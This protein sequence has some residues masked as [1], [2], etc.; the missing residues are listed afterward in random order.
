MKKQI[1]EY[2]LAAFEYQF[3][4]E[5][6]SGVFCYS[7][8]HFY[9]YWDVIDKEHSISSR[10][11]SFKLFLISKYL[12]MLMYYLTNKNKYFKKVHLG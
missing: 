8:R 3:G 4:G 12:H 10:Y 9:F 2:N 1:K 6:E 11:I 7:M 5:D